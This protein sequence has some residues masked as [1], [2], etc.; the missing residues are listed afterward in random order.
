MSLIRLHAAPLPDDYDGM[1]DQLDPDYSDSIAELRRWAGSFNTETAMFWESAGDNTDRVWL[2][3]S[4]QWVVT[5]TL[6]GDAFVGTDWARR[7]LAANGH[8]D[9]VTEHIDVEH[10]GRGR[11]EIGPEIKFRVPEQVR[12][13]IDRLAAANGRTRAEQLRA[14][15]LDTVPLS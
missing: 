3:P 5:S 11:P 13:A 7:W 14:I 8:A 10:D 12:D 2:T 9:V 15:V 4:G 1:L 6:Y